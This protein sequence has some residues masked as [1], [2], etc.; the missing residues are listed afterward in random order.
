MTHSPSQQAPAKS[1]DFY[2]GVRAAIAVL[3]KFER[4]G[5]GIESLNE[6]RTDCYPPG[7]LG[8]LLPKPDPAKAL[9]ERYRQTFPNCDV[10][11]THMD[12]E[13]AFARWLIDQGVVGE[14]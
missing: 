1:Q 9:V 12:D 4:M 5:D 2:D 13:L 8:A 14:G 6:W 10:V 11:A 7:M 3:P